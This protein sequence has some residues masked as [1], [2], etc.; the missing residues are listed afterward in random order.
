MS[1]ADMVAQLAQ[2][3]A[4]EQAVE[5]NTRLGELVSAQDAAGAAGLADL[6][7]REITAD[8]SVIHVDGP[9][10]A[11]Q[12]TSD[13][14]LAGGEV[15]IKDASG[16]EVRRLPFGAGTSPI[17]VPWDGKDAAGVPVPAGAYA[18][19]V[20][21]RGGDGAA[22]PARPQVRGL[23]DAVELGPD[24]PRLRLGHARISP[25]AVTTIARSGGTP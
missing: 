3:S 12:V 10:P 15:V 11:L 22:A 17:P 24:G 1:G 25:A 19:E 21:A 5:T 16:K 14:T 4:V 8:A 2:F 18:I 9:P 23:V 13:A 20:T 6:V 7:G